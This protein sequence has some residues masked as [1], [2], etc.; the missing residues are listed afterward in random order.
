LSWQGR[1][2]LI[3]DLRM[4]WAATLYR[5]RGDIGPLQVETLRFLQKAVD[6]AYAEGVKKYDEGRLKMNLSRGE[7]IGNYVDRWVRGKLQSI[8]DDHRI[9]YGIGKDITINNRDYDTSL[10]SNTYTIP[11][12]RLGD[13]SFDWTLTAK[14]IS[15]QQIR[16]FF[17]ADSKPQGVVIVRPNKIGSDNTYLIPRPADLKPK[18]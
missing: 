1:N 15:N 13:I 12:A 14:S 10:S 16:G 17:A 18:R 7:A 5:M 9:S 4:T 8:Y 2:N 11:D 6:E 3:D